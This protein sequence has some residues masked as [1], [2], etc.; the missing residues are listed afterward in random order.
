MPARKQ[1]KSVFTALGLFAPMLAV[2]AACS[3]SD[4]SG[5]TAGDDARRRALIIG[6]DG[7][8]NKLIA[9]MLAEGRLPNLAAIAR[10]GVTGLV[11]NGGSCLRPTG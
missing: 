7:A 5:T 9:P 10:D 1:T 6:I 8:T 11:P 4:G 2:F 3:P